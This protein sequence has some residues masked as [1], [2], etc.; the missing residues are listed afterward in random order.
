MSELMNSEKMDAVRTCSER[1]GQFVA[2]STC[3]STATLTFKG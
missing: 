3:K 1:D 2:A